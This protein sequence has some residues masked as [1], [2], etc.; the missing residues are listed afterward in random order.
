M[1]PAPALRRGL[2]ILFAMLASLL[3]IPWNAEAQGVRPDQEGAMDALGSVVCTTPVDCSKKCFAAKKFC[4]EYA[5]HPYKPD[6]G[7]GALIDC[8]DTFPPARL[9][10]SYTCLYKYSNGDV[11]VFSRAA[12][13]GPI[14]PPAP[15]PLCVYKS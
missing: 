5:Y 6:V 8:I 4:V 13:I 10:G 7:N 14:H 1:K 9:G 11:C 12:Q 15:P 3:C 2:A